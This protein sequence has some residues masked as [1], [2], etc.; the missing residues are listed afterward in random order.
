MVSRFEAVLSIGVLVLVVLRKKSSAGFTQAGARASC[1]ACKP[2]A[3]V[4][5]WLS[6]CAAAASGGS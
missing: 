2:S 3:I 1:I 5:Q 4:F 6:V